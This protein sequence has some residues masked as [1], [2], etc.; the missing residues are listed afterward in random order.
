MVAKNGGKTFFGKNASCL[1]GYPG[2]SK[3]STKS[4]SRTF[5]KINAFY[6]EIQDGYK[7]WQEIDFYRTIS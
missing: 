1:C 6:T 3:I 2:G 7:K 4:L 5:S